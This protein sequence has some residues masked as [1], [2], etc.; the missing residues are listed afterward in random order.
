MKKVL[1][2]LEFFHRSGFCHNSISPESIW[3]TTV[4]QLEI[5]ILDARFADLGTAKSFTELGPVARGK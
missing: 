5:D 3:L 2:A 1:E 4:N